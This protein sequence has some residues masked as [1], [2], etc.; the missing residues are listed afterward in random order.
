MGGSI[1]MPVGGILT[2]SPDYAHTLSQQLEQLG[3][4]VEVCHPDE[5]ANSPAD[6]EIDLEVCSQSE[7]VDRAT[8]L[9]VEFGTEVAGGPPASP[10]SGAPHPTNPARGPHPG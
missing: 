2:R 1:G 7:A 9:A 6:M 5:P 3:Y 8:E 4:M 10:A